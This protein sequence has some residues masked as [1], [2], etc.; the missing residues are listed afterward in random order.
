MTLR[1]PATKFERFMAMVIITTAVVIEI[2]IIGNNGMNTLLANGI[3]G[4]I[5][6]TSI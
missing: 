1:V 4:F 6:F 2:K 3:I 5:Y